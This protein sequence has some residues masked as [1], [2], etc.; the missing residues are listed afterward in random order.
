MQNSAARVVT[1][2]RKR[3]H[4]TPILKELHWLP[5]RCRVDF[6]ILLLTHKALH[7]KAPTYLSD[8]LTFKEGRQSRSTKL[9]LLAVPITKCVMFG[10]RAFSVYAPT[11]WNKS[12]WIFV[13]LTVLKHS[14]QQSKHICLG[15]ISASHLM[16]CFYTSILSLNMLSALEQ[17][18][19]II[20]L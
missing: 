8:M 2:T 5:V 13:V 20:A 10:D 15:N 9:N 18:V 7:G 1:D 17:F 11:Q 16:Y 14:S 19:L 3:E 12:R 4:V 6:K